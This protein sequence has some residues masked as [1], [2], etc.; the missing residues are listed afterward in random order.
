VVDDVRNLRPQVF[1]LV[2]A[3]STFCN[4]HDD[5]AKPAMSSG[6]LQEVDKAATNTAFCAGKFLSKMRVLIRF[7]F[8]WQEESLDKLA[9]KGQQ[10]GREVTA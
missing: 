4:F 1:A 10:K 9:T 7:D 3:L 5:Q 2:T 8:K 6:V